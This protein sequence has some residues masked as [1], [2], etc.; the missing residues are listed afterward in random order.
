MSFNRLVENLRSFSWKEW[1]LVAMV[2]VVFAAMFGTVGLTMGP[3]VGYLM[4]LG[5]RR[6]KANRHTRTRLTR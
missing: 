6:A 2:V 4:A 5:L 3:L 1:L